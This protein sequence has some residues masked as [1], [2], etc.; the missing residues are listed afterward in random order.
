MT[1]RGTLI[2]DLDGTLAETAGDLIAALNFVLE[3]ENVAPVPVEA[4]RSLLG[5]G[6]RALIQ[7]GFARSERALD[8]AKLE[9]L[10]ANFLSYYNA[11][12]VEHTHLFP[13]LEAALD[14]FAARGWRFGVCTNK[15]EASSKLLLGKLGVTDRFDFICGQDTFGVGKPDPRPL[16][17]TIRTMGGQ[18]ATSIM[19]GDSMTDVLTARGGRTAVIAVDFG[20][21]D[22]PA[23]E[24]GADRVISHFDALDEAVR[25]VRGLSAVLTA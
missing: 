5:A 1:M 25:D 11:H 6:G 10:F 18:P 9:V 13:G 8:A 22:I 4:A 17:E 3:S 21:T 16:L 23:A 2:F 12:I 20:Y 19:V 14:R 15:L 7:R 24:L